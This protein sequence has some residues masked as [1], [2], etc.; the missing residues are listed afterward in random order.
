[1]EPI[2]TGISANSQ[3]RTPG[4]SFRRAAV[5]FAA[6]S[7]G[8]LV[9]IAD[10]ILIV[11]LMVALWGAD[12][13]GIWM[14]VRSIPAWLSISEMGF[15]SAAGNMMTTAVAQGDLHLARRLHKT[16]SWLINSISAIGLSIAALIVSL[17]PLSQLLN[18]QLVSHWEFSFSCLLACFY[19][20]SIF[21]TQLYYSVAR[22]VELHGTVAYQIQITRIGEVI[23]SLLVIFLGGQLI[24]TSAAFLVARIVGIAFIRRYIHQKIAWSCTPASIDLALAKGMLTPAIGYVVVPLVQ[25]LQ[26]QGITMVL[27]IHTSPAMVLAYNSMRT[28]ARMPQLLGMSIGRTAWPEMSA[29]IARGDTALLKNLYFRTTFIG[30][31]WGLLSL[32]ALVLFGR[33]FFRIWTMDRIHFD[34]SCFYLLAIGSSVSALAT[35]QMSILN[36]AGRHTS[37]SF[38]WTILSALTLII[39]YLLG[40]NADFMVTSYI[41]L[42]SDFLV[43]L[44]VAAASFICLLSFTQSITEK[45]QSESGH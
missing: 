11:P 17:V 35:T 39:C 43:L 38:L 24:E 7:L 1:M 2:S 19:T 26:L 21:Q 25:A 15:A 27:A 8:N 3:I 13:L 9:T 16:T 23:L 28:L 42:V 22:S 29:A 20:V 30:I 40:K 6:H 32:T 41:L 18:C 12:L 14:I 36:A 33:T 37:S 34:T 10:R 4:S 44:F 45:Q 31:A 5:V